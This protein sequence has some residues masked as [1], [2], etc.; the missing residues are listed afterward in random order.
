MSLVPP[1]ISSQV[2]HGTVGLAG[3]IVPAATRGSSAS[4]VGSAFSEHACSASQRSR[5]RCWPRVEH[6]LGVVADRRQLKPPSTVPSAVSCRAPRPWPRTPSRC[7]RSLPAPSSGRVLLVPDDPRHGVVRAGERDVRLD[8]VARGV[9]VQRR[10]A[11]R[12]ARRPPAGSRS[13]RSPGRRPWASATPAGVTPSQFAMP[14][15]SGLETK[16]WFLSAPGAFAS[17]SCQVT[18]GPGFVGS[19]AEPP[20]TEGF[21][22]SWPVW[23]F[24]DG[25]A[26]PLPPLPRLWP[27]K[28][29]LPVGVVEP[30]REDV[31][32]A[33]AGARRV[34]VPRRPR[35]RP[36]SAG[37]VDRR[38]LA[39]LALVEVQRPRERRGGARAAADRAVA[40]GRPRAVGKRRG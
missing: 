5:R 29:H 4:L 34:L 23:M 7:R 28:I 26:G 36:A 15:P 20:A 22:A 8:A 18:H 3:F 32:G 13:R 11:R 19:T 35:H 1:T 2:T 17:V 21:S 24:S 30:A 39:V 31:V 14:G 38:R 6:A 12:G 37:E 25:T 40:A 27:A 9:D 10:I 16:I 33:E